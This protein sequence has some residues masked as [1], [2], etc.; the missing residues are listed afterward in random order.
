VEEVLQVRQTQ[1]VLHVRQTCKSNSDRMGLVTPKSGMGEE[2]GQVLHMSRLWLSEGVLAPTSQY[3]VKT[4]EQL[5]EIARF[6]NNVK[7]GPHTG[8]RE[9]FTVR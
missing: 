8:G 9:E 5:K 6:S 1:E 3:I 7:T 2:R 4:S